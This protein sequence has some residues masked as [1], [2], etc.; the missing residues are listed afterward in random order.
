MTDT[1]TLFSYDDSSLAY[2]PNITINPYGNL[3]FSQFIGT[4][5]SYVTLSNIQFDAW[6]TISF[7][8]DSSTTLFVSLNNTS[9]TT[10]N[11]QSLPNST[12]RLYCSDNVV[13]GGIGISDGNHSYIQYAPYD[14]SPFTTS[15]IDFSDPSNI[16]VS[17]K[18]TTSLSIVDNNIPTTGN[19]TVVPK[20]IISDVNNIYY[21]NNFYS[22]NSLANQSLTIQPTTNNTTNNTGYKNSYVTFY[23]PDDLTGTSFFY[24]T[25]SS[26]LYF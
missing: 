25:H 19:N 18:D 6:N 1:F 17:G 7:G 14:K 26:N 21:S 3:Q 4:S 22:I 12:W 16:S 20:K 10:S 13:I 15:Y 8:R 2:S 9:V 11:I 5:W 23:V 24:N